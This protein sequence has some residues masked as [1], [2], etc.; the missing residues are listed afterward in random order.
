[1]MHALNRGQLRKALL[2]MW[3]WS[4]LGNRKEIGVSSIL[5]TLSNITVKLANFHRRRA[6]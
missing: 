4:K 1:M 5:V 6:R 3:F 2:P